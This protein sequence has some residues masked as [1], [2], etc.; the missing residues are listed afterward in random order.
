MR[1]VYLDHN[2]TSPLLPA[3]RAHLLELLDADLGNP[4]SLHESGRR[5]RHVID[6][7]R[8]RVAAALGVHETEIVF[9]AGGTESIQLALLGAANAAGRARGLVASRIEHSAVLGALE[10]AAGLGH[11]TELVPV[12]AHGFVDPQ[13]V[14]H[15]MARCA[16]GVVSIQV[17]NNE[18][19]T[20]QPTAAIAA[21]AHAAAPTAK[22]HPLVHCDA[23]QALGR[24][25][26]ELARWGIDLASF[27]AHKLGGPSGVGWLWVR[28]GVALVPPLR[29]G[30][31][32]HGLRP[33]TEPAAL[34]SAAALALELTLREQSAAALRWSAQ[35]RS[36]HAALASELPELVLHGPPLEDP[37]RLPNTLSLGLPGVDG[38]IIVT[39]LDL[40]GLRASAGSACASGSAAPS[41][42]LQA[43]GLGEDRARGGLR[44]SLGW[45]TSDADCKRAV[46][47]LRSVLGPHRASR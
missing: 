17:A 18:I 41:H 14:A 34:W 10:V 37:R 38:K 15:A 47:I 40:A 25:P 24:V 42:V 11:P 7:A 22:P 8:E 1:A 26:V 33:G 36:I 21:A 46:E 28:R 45:N 39:K 29:G 30:G 6:T 3:V 4:S 16:A 44:L 13:A 23:V 27:S 2:A 35:C 31:Q 32:E 9:T 5:A 43:L 19:G 12:D 20:V